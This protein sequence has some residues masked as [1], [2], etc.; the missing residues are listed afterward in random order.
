[1]MGIMI[2]AK[3]GP[4]PREMILKL[5]CDGDHGFLERADTFE[6]GDFIEM[7]SA[8][9]ALGWKE[10]YIVA[11]TRQSHGPKVGLARLF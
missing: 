3:P 5:R 6:G 9:T 11:V 4:I 8:A 10:T 2:L 7:R 1:M